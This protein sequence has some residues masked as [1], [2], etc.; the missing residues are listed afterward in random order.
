MRLNEDVKTYRG[1]GR[2]RTVLLST[3]VN[4]YSQSFGESKMAATFSAV[5]A[6]DGVE[7]RNRITPTEA[8]AP[9]RKTSSPNSLSKV[10]SSRGSACALASTP[11]SDS[12]G[13]L[14]QIQSTSCP[15]CR[16][17]TTQ[18]PGMFS[19]AQ[20]RTDHLTKLGRQ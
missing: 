14:S 7:I 8:F 6:G 2:I 12:P 17:K 10:N 9:R 5:V 1:S 3:T 16:S 18:S 13:A 4:L 15:R 11:S 19:L 20:R